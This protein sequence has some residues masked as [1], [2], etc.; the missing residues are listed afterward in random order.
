ML[1]YQDKLFFELF[2][3]IY[4]PKRSVLEFPLFPILT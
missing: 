3:P 1:V 4:K 2:V